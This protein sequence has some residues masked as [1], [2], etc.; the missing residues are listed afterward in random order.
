MIYVT[1]LLL[2]LLLIELLILLDITDNVRSMLRIS[3]EAW[4]TITCSELDDNAKER[5]LRRCSLDVLKITVTFLLKLISIAAILYGLYI[6][7]S[8]MF[9]LSGERLIEVSLLPQTVIAL[10]VFGYLYA[11]LR[12]VVIRRLQSR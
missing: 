6:L 1:L 11:R 2:S 12:N 9:S 5:V 3:Q 4:S 8:S 7:L 10:I